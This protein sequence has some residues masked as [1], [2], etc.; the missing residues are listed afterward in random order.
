MVNSRKN[1]KW[2]L[3]PLDAPKSLTSL[4]KLLCSPRREN[5]HWE[6]KK[7]LTSP[8]DRSAEGPGETKLE[9]SKWKQEPEPRLGWL[10]VTS[11]FFWVHFLYPSTTLS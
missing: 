5:S 7:N 9:M 8:K 1:L 11:L 6:V 3:I 2:L 4:V 10:L